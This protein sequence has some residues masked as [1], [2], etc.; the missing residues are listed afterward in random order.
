MQIFTKLRPFL[1]FCQLFGVIPYSVETEEF[2]AKTKF[3]KFSFS[4]R[5]PVAWWFFFLCTFTVV[6]S[7]WDFKMIW[8]VLH[9]DDGV[10][11]SHVSRIISVFVLQEHIFYIAL[12]VMSRYVI[13]KY[14]CFRRI[15]YFLQK[16]NSELMVDDMSPDGIPTVTRSVMLSII[17]AIVGVSSI[18][19]PKF[20]KR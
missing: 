7:C 20:L 14:V 8:N 18:W 15:V 9:E 5:H 6:V 1:V 16:I 11:R 2:P 10:L 17:S 13:I 12:M 4:L 19:K 3:K